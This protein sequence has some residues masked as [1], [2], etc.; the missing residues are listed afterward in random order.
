MLW[1]LFRFQVQ[2]HNFIC[3]ILVLWPDCGFSIIQTQCTIHCGV[4]YYLFLDKNEQYVILGR[5]MFCSECGKCDGPPDKCEIRCPDDTAFKVRIMFFTS[6]NCSVDCYYVV[7]NICHVITVFQRLWWSVYWLGPSLWQL[8][9]LFLSGG[10]MSW[11]E[12][13]TVQAKKIENW[14]VP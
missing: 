7:A 9:P 13:Y 5:N 4:N 14:W 1:W 3:Y 11:R 2:G 12:C 10:A 6:R 8:L